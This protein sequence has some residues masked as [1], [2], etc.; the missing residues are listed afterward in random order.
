MVGRENKG[1]ITSIN[2]YFTIYLRTI[3]YDFFENI[4]NSKLL[5]YK[6]W[7]KESSVLHHKNLTC[8]ILDK[9]ELQDCK[10]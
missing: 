7:A 6:A 3:G 4:N 8:F 2:K 9:N 10:N 5:K 1:M